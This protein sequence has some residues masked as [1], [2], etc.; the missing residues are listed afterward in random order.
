MTRQFRNRRAVLLQALLILILAVTGY[1]HLLFAQTPEPDMTELRRALDS[2]LRAGRTMQALYHV[3]TLAAEFGWKSE[4]AW[5]AGSIWESVGDLSRAAAYWEVAAA[6]QP[7]NIALTR[8]L[9][10]AYLNT[11]QWPGAISSLRRLVALAPE[12]DWAQFYLA[13]LELPQDAES[14]RERLQRLAEGSL[15]QE[16]ALMLLSVMERS[17]QGE[18][19]MR[20]TLGAALAAR[21]L[22]PFAERTFAAAS[23][24]DNPLPE[25]LAYAGLARDRQGKDGSQQI[26]EAVALASDNSQ[27]RYL[28]GL[29]LRAMGDN[30]GSRAAFESAVALDP[31]NPAYAAELGTA[32]QLLGN[33]AEAESWL[34]VAIRTS[35]DDPGFQQLLADFYAASLNN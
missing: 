17:Q 32:F 27:V 29:H 30:E 31:L 1:T 19:Q 2:N 20:L 26:A 10:A 34:Q 4:L 6:A 7:N 35:G 15:Y 9:A 5:S 13:L 22:W 23:L 12:D 16:T 14:A 24:V 11:Q 28:Q 25:A 33:L 8:Q 21:D 3:E 18:A